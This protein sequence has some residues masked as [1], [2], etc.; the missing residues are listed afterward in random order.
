LCFL[1]AEQFVVPDVNKIPL[2]PVATVRNGEAVGE[3][4]TLEASQKLKALLNVESSD[5]PFC[6]QFDSK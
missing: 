1:V 3:G 5:L 6:T 2:I 4:A